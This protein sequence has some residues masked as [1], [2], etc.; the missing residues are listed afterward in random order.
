V[1][2]FLIG[3]WTA[4]GFSVLAH[5]ILL[6]AIAVTVGTFETARRAPQ[7]FGGLGRGQGGEHE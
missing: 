5:V 4:F 1:F 7:Y 3:S 6:G 2:A